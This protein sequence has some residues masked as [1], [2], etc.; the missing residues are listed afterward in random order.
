MN[1][2]FSGDGNA[3]YTYPDVQVDEALGKNIESSLSQNMQ[4]VA[5][6]LGEKLFFEKLL[7]MG[8]VAEEFLE[9]D[10]KTSPSVQCVISPDKQV[11]IVSTHDQLLGGEDGQVF[12]GAVFLRINNTVFLLLKKEKRS[13]CCPGRQRSARQVRHR[14]YFCKARRWELET[15]CN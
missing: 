8:G 14:F 5:R 13:P 2:G 1:D 4:T 10:V 11:Q 15:F 6:D 12:I 7:G 9:G 3:M